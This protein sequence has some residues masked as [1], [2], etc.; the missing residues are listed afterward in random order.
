MGVMGWLVRP[1][2]V[3]EKAPLLPVPTASQI[4]LENLWP[5]EANERDWKVARRAAWGYPNSTL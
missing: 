1:D 3:L 2:C 5:S 4:Q